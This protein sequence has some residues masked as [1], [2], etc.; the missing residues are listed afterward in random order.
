MNPDIPQTL[1]AGAFVGGEFSQ[2]RLYSTL[3]AIERHASIDRSQTQHEHLQLL[4]IHRNHGRYIT[5]TGN[6]N[7]FTDNRYSIFAALKSRKAA[8]NFR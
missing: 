4:M 1:I 3:M 2:S 8:G 7:R 6:T 5:W